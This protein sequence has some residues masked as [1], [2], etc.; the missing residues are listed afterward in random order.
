M[1]RSVFSTLAL[2]AFAT[3]AFCASAQAHEMWTCGAY[4][5]GVLKADLGYGHV[6]GVPE[7]IVPDRVHIFEPLKIVTPDGTT[8]LTQT[9]ENYHYE[10]KMDLAKG[11]YI[12]RADYKPTFWAKGPEGW[13][14]ADRAG[15]KEQTKTDAT[16]VEEAAMYAK[17]VLNVDGATSTNLITKPVGQKLEIVPQ[18]NPA[19]VK[20]G[21]RF[22][23]QVLL[24]GQ[25]AKQVEVKGVYDGFNGRASE[26]DPANGY[27]AF[28]GKTDLKGMVEIIPV[29]GGMWN[30]QASMTPAYPD[31]AVADEYSLTARLVFMIND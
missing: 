9:G 12:I 1:K 2:A 23:V 29:K 7:V 18:V 31:K 14:Q 17:Y 24:D 19:T 11:D 5:D 21:G 20:A 4:K 16:Y 6:F 28:Y 25:P 26:K 3:A 22:P 15:Y 10:G 27:K 8:V 13:K 30:V